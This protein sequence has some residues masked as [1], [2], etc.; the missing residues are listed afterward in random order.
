MNSAITIQPLGALPAITPGTPVVATFVVSQRGGG[1]VD[2]VFGARGLAPGEAIFRPPAVSL[3]AG[4]SANVSVTITANQASPIAIQA[5]T[6]GGQLLAELPI[7][8]GPLP[9]GMGSLPAQAAVA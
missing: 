6:R 5:L 1:P 3:P 2:L 9:A 8:A 4:G 7:G